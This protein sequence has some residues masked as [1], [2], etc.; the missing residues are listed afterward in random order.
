MHENNFASLMALAKELV[1]VIASKNIFFKDTIWAKNAEEFAALPYRVAE[2]INSVEVVKFYE[3]YAVFN[4]SDTSLKTL[5]FLVLTLLHHYDF[6][7]A[8]TQDN[9]ITFNYVPMKTKMFD[10]NKIMNTYAKRYN[11]WYYVCFNVRDKDGTLLK[12]EKIV[13]NVLS[14]KN[15]ECERRPSLY[16]PEYGFV[17]NNV[18]ATHVVLKKDDHEYVVEKCASELGKCQTCHSKLYSKFVEKNE[19]TYCLLCYRMKFPLPGSY[20]IKEN[21]LKTPQFSDEYTKF[22]DYYYKST[23]HVLIDYAVE[24]AKNICEIYVDL[25]DVM[26]THKFISIRELVCILV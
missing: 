26:E 2:C 17:L 13:D 23:Q 16:S 3:K 10:T 9:A 7:E 1:N 18:H 19:K 8:I 4:L 24:N 5:R 15:F 6:I 11:A 20:T 25:K 14:I 22:D 12:D 21:I